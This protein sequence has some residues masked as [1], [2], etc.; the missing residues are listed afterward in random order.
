VSISTTAREAFI[1]G[2][3]SYNSAPYDGHTLY[4]QLNQVYARTN[5]QPDTCYVDRGYRGH[6]V[7]TTR[8][9]IAGQRRCLT[10]LGKRLLKRRNS[11]EP[12]IGHLKAEGKLDRCFLKGTEG[13]AL[14]ALLS[15]CGQN[16]RRLL[17]WLYFAL[18]NYR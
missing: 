12:V 4:D 18:K 8:I 2:A 1:V 13:D 9:V 11:I 5:T 3:R 16:L 7:G 10:R 17:H 15:A 14:N 6:G